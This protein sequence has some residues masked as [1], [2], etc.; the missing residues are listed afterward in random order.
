MKSSKVPDATVEIVTRSRSTANVRTPLARTNATASD[1]TSV[2][3]A[4]ATIVQKQPA[5]PPLD[6]A[7]HPCAR[8]SRFDRRRRRHAR[9]VAC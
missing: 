2:R 1:A 5:R 4:T 6:L 7:V 3:D 8:C 9:L